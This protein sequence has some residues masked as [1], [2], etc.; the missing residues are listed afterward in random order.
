MF[1]LA[2]IGIGVS[3]PFTHGRAAAIVAEGLMDDDEDFL[4]DDNGDVLFED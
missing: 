1:F 3:I 2:M 4:L